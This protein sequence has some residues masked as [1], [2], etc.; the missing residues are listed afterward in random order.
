MTKSWYQSKTI[1]SAIAACIISIISTG[2]EIYKEKEITET[3]MTL[4]VG[5]LIALY[6]TIQ[7]RSKAEGPLVTPR[8]F[9][10]LDEP[11][12]SNSD[13]AINTYED[14]EKEL[15]LLNPE[16]PDEVQV[17]ISSEVESTEGEV[18][19]FQYVTD[20]NG[21]Y[22]II[23]NQDTVIKTKNVDSSTLTD[24]EVQSLEEG[25]T[26][27]ISSYKKESIN[28]LSVILEGQEKPFYLFIPH[29][30]LFNSKQEEIDL[31]S[32]SNI[33]VNP[34]KT[35]FKLPGYNST[36]FLEDSII[37]SGHF[38]WAEATKNGTR[39]PVSKEIVDNI[40]SMARDLET[41][42]SYFGNKPM[43]ITSWYRDP[44]SNRAVGGA[45]NSSHLTGKAVDFYIPGLDIFDVEKQII[46]WWR[47]GGVGK[48]AK[49]GFVHIA[50]DGWYRVWNY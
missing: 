48:G 3:Q 36:F 44:K 9:P 22:Y 45:S 12:K 40:I 46:N 16:N 38:S 49:K 43:R 10:G 18:D 30:K 37:P 15:N 33:I 11:V 2:T 4:I 20:K 7:G 17:D 39:I 35:P 28:S 41:V 50:S 8:G 34:K 24:R 13:I 26:Y 27:F 23:P 14:L 21:K 32:E 6:T 19:F 25:K 5:S 47:K 31:S 42:R 29:I 1:Q